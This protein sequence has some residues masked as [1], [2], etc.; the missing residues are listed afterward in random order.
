MA[1]LALIFSLAAL[2][3]GCLFLQAR[4]LPGG[5]APLAV[6]S[7]VVVLLYGGGLLGVLPVVSAA[8]YAAG[9]VLGVAA[10]MQLRGTG[11]LFSGPV[12]VAAS[13]FW[14]GALVLLVVLAAA[15]P[16]LTIFDE[17]SFWGTAT[18]LTCL[19]D[20]LYTECPIG[21]PWQI[22]QTPAVP[23]LGYWVQRFAPYADWQL[24]W[25]VDLLILAAVAA[26]TE[27]AAAGGWRLQLP[28]ALMGLLTPFA[29]VLYSHT[30][31]LAAPYLE[32]MGDTVVGM[33]FG[34]AVAFWWC[35][36]S[37]SP[38]LWWLMLPVACLVGSVKDN[39][40]VLGLAAAGIAAAD[41]VLFGRYDR[42]RKLSAGRLAARC[43][44]ALALLAAP[45]AQYLVWSRY[46]AA[47]VAQNAQT[48]GMGVTSQPLSAVLVQGIRLL[49]GLP[50]AEY[51]TQRGELAFAYAESMVQLFLHR[52][53]SLLGSGA[54]VVTVI[55]LLFAGAVLLA[56]TARHKLRAV[57][58]AVCS[59]ACFGGYWLMLLLSYAFILKDSSPAEP[60]S[61]NRYFQSY[62]IGWFLLALAV[63]VWCA[64]SARW[65]EQLRLGQAGVLVLSLV[66]CVQCFRALEPQF[67][68]FGVNGFAYTE[69]RQTEQTAEWAAAQI[70]EGETVYLIRQG[71]DGFYWFEYSCRLLP[72]ILVY[73]DGGG[74]YGLSLYEAEGVNLPY[75]AAQLHTAVRQTGA[76][77]L[78]VARTDE[79][80]VR[81]YAHLFSD[82]LD[83]ACTAPALYR[84]T[85]TGFTLAEV[86]EVGS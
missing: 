32:A 38:Q 43:G 21:T 9:L 39:T 86:M 82:R 81:S 48:G 62:Y 49:V 69:R 16:Y 22:T 15:Q 3:G 56:P 26:V 47:L 11:R 73:G 5:T 84:V 20:R 40:F 77:W 27:C 54:A 29:L 68:V 24:I 17:Y 33:L 12:S 45:A 74:T 63:F 4:G 60:A 66:F 53:V 37:R 7:S 1:V 52:D 64:A 51:Y 46:T 10:L 76:A 83:E 31:V 2:A 80:F 36:R 6:L 72:H 18:R 75:T 35:T 71:D 85:E 65:P 41:L 14:C 61:Y 30:S 79:V 55:G 28:V 50:A 8:L 57:V 67:T 19:H 44:G 78:L 59:G 70:P 42:R 23:L 58:T 25:A 13:V 34:G